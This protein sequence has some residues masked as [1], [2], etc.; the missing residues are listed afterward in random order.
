MAVLQCPE[1]E[2]RFTSEPDLDD[3]LQ[4][5]HPDFSAEPATD[6]DRLR[7]ELRRRHPS[8]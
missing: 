3:H 5:D 7:Q 1:C 6:E 4:R 8:A 2:L